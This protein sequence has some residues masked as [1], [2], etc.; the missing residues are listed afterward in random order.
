MPWKPF[1]TYS[2][3]G[4][5]IISD[6]RYM[7]VATSDKKAK[8]WAAPVFF[9]YDSKYNFYFL[10]AVDSRH[11]ENIS[12]NPNVSIVIY[13][14]TSEIGLSDGVQIEAKASMVDEK[15]VARV[16]K[17]YC[18]RLFPNSD[19]PA[20]QRYKP[21]QYSG[22]S[23]FRFF[24]VQVVQTYVTGVD[25]RMDVDLADRDGED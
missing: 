1:K 11:A 20:T 7:V 3:K 12:E 23:E 8:P 25:R 19:V 9:A 21:E 13:D 15:D 24:K 14:S 10:S 16:I 22:A 2:E 5:H 4:R 6:N 18:D 17:I